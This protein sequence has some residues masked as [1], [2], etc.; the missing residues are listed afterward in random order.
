MRLLSRNQPWQLP[1]LDF[2]ECRCTKKF[3][4]LLGGGVYN[5]GLAFAWVV[6]DGEPL[7]SLHRNPASESS[8]GNALLAVRLCESLQSLPTESRSYVYSP[9]RPKGTRLIHPLCG[10]RHLCAVALRQGCYKAILVDGESL[11]AVCHIIHLNPV[12]A[13]LVEASCLEQYADRCRFRCGP[14]S[15]K[16]RLRWRRLALGAAAHVVVF[17]TGGLIQCIVL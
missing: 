3:L 6:P 8:G 1:L 2:R 9:S 15:W 7:S 10:L 11:G 16:L 12:R 4:G 17:E 13:G 5:D 14:G